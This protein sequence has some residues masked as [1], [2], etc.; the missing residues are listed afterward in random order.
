MR[1]SRRETPKQ[2]KCDIK[3]KLRQQ[4]TSRAQQTSKQTS[5]PKLSAGARV[6]RKYEIEPYETHSPFDGPR[7]IPSPGTSSP[8]RLFPV[9][10]TRGGGVGRYRL[11]TIVS[12]G[13]ASAATP[14]RALL[15]GGRSMSLTDRVDS[16]LLSPST[17]ALRF[18]PVQKASVSL[19]DRAGGS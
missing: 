10:T 16:V 12:T 2:D 15:A 18:A 5:S 11:G 13:P 14:P 19:P 1:R 4:T 8:L 7:R 6:L 9:H 3:R 17:D